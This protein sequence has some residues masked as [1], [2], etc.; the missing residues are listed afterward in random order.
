MMKR[1][2]THGSA[3]THLVQRLV[4]Y[5]NYDPELIRQEL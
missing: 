1:D 2:Q 5:I 3:F 4:W